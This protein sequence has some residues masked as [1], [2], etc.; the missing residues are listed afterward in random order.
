MSDWIK[1]NGLAENQNIIKSCISSNYTPIFTE[2]EIPAQSKV[3]P[4]TFPTSLT[5]TLDES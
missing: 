5:C 2:T 3:N 4:S 1:D